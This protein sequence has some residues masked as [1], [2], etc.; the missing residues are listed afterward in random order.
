M[1][2]EAGEGW[3]QASLGHMGCGFCPKGSGEP[4]E[5]FQHCGEVRIRWWLFGRSGQEYKQWSEWRRIEVACS[6]RHV[7]ERE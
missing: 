2:S 4:Q 1:R 5:S 6:G 7:T 3:G